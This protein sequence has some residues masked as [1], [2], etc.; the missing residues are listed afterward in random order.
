M[1]AAPNA[2]TWHKAL[3]MATRPRT[4]SKRDRPVISLILP[5]KVAAG[6]CPTTDERTVGPALA[7]LETR[8]VDFKP[9]YFVL[10]S[11]LF[12]DR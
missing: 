3:S 11:D 5:G 8:I 7:T 12:Q 4:R 2:Q 1:V 9:H 10:Q 6:S